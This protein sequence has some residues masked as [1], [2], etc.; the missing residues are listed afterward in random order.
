MHT[1]AALQVAPLFPRGWTR[2]IVLHLSHD[3]QKQSVANADN[4]LLWLDSLHVPHLTGMSLPNRLL[5]RLEHTRLSYVGRRSPKVQVARPL[6][7]PRRA[8]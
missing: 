7:H 3:S 8:D 6:T 2:C 4:T 1:S 5:G